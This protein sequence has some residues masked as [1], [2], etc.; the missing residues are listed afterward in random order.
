[1]YD[2]SLERGK[3]G[4]AL[5]WAVVVGP[6]WLGMGAMGLLWDGICLDCRTGMGVWRVGLFKFVEIC[7]G[8]FMGCCI[9]GC[10][11][12]SPLLSEVCYKPKHS[13]ISLIYREDC[14]VIVDYGTL[15]HYFWYHNTRWTRTA[16]NNCNISVQFTHSELWCL[17][18]F[19]RDWQA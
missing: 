2:H 3:K 19:L 9:V 15:W 12:M 7:C 1:M 18:W 11:V 14:K 4:L 17:S 10:I 5:A 8:W 16:H 13:M 6:E